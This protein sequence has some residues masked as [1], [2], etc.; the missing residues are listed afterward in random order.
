MH[1]QSS[2]C[3]VRATYAWSELH[4]HG[5][6]CTRMVRAPHVTPGISLHLPSPGAPPAPTLKP[7]TPT[8]LLETEPLG[9]ACG[10]GGCLGTPRAPPAG[11]TLPAPRLRGPGVPPWDM[12]PLIAPSSPGAAAALEGS[13]PP[14]QRR[15]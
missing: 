13:E 1:G 10:R 6:S 15:S 9:Q 12:H 14:A 4:M 3:V 7:G 8:L 2:T 5:Q 11:C